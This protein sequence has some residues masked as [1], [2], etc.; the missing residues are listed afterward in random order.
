M[1]FLWYIYFSHVNLCIYHA[2]SNSIKAGREERCEGLG[3]EAAAM[4]EATRTQIEIIHHYFT[5]A[6]RNGLWGCNTYANFMY[7][8]WI[9]MANRVSVLYYPSREIEAGSKWLAK[10]N[11]VFIGFLKQQWV[12]GETLGMKGLRLAPFDPALFMFTISW[13]NELG[14]LPARKSVYISSPTNDINTFF[15]AF[16]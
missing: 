14:M 12:D 13:C 7:M 4:A 8:T 10:R 9:T 15:C 5:F 1:G 2:F 3:T 6:R 11:G 16:L